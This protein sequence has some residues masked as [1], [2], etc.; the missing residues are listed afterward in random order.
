M[1]TPN[2]TPST[3]IPLG[4]AVD[5]E[6]TLKAKGLFY[7]LWAL[8]D[9]RRGRP[10]SMQTIIAASSDSRSG[11]ETALRD[12]TDA[13]YVDRQTKQLGSRAAFTWTLRP[14]RA[15]ADTGGDAT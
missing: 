12:L 4:P 1:N 5:V 7:T 14:N 3:T 9:V 11:T 2:N 13:G 8:Q 10:F 6:L 15:D